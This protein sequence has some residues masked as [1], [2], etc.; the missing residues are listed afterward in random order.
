MQATREGFVI[1]MEC[2]VHI[3]K[4]KLVSLTLFYILIHRP[5][6][7]MVQN[8]HDM[9]KNT[10]YAL[11]LIITSYTTLLCGRQHLQSRQ[12]HIHFAPFDVLPTCI[13][14]CV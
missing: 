2:Y 6:L 9:N 8:I 14:T 13:Y 7:A 11:L 4:C 12:N 3:Y 10:C 1:E 5:F